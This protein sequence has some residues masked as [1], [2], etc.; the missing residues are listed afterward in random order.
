M[1]NLHR[2]LRR[3]HQKPRRTR[4]SKHRPAPVDGRPSVPISICSSGRGDGHLA[5]AYSTESIPYRTRR[6]WAA[7]AAAAAA[8]AVVVVVAVA[9]VVASC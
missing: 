2:L 1:T 5:I 9:A 3:H 4:N 6:R 7:T 8:A